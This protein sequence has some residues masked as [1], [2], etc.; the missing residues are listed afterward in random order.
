MI[1][2]SLEVIA[3]LIFEVIAGKYDWNECPKIASVQ[4]S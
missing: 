1:V 2:S 4:P 3:A